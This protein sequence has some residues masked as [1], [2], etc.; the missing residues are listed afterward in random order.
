MFVKNNSAA[1]WN[2]KHRVGLMNHEEHS[3]G[4]LFSDR[5]QAVRGQQHVHCSKKNSIW[6]PNQDLW[7][8]FFFLLIII[9]S[10]FLNLKNMLDYRG[11]KECVCCG[12]Q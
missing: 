11:V 1:C 5:S 10:R 12:H 8:A 7:H 9:L 6:E 2:K 3:G 4:T